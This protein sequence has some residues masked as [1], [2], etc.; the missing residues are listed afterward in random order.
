MRLVA[1]FLLSTTYIQAQNLVPNPGFELFYDCPTQIGQ[2]SLTKDWFS[3]NSGTPEYYN[4]QCRGSWNLAKGGQGYA[5]L[6]NFGHYNKVVEYI[7]AK[8]TDSLKKGQTYYVAMDVLADNSPYFTDRLDIHL[9]MNNPRIR[10]WEPLF[11]STSI[12][13]KK[14][15][16]D[17]MDEWVTIDGEF[18]ARGGERYIVI[19]NFSRAD[20]VNKIANP[21]FT[22]AIRPG[23][24]TYYFVDNVI[25]VPLEMK[26]QLLERDTSDATILRNE[27]SISLRP[28]YFGF[29]KHRLMKPELTY[30]DSISDIEGIRSYNVLLTGHTDSLGSDAYNLDLS[31]RRVETVSK[32]LLSRGFES[33][34]IQREF[35]GESRP[36]AT[37]NSKKG[38]AEN[39]RVSI[40]IHGKRK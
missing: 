21:N 5:G 2:F 32:Y 34:S 40:S 13:N 33:N 3:A 20:R 35:K 6:I 4:A 10:A 17:D 37:N 31:K 27:D 39:R 16:L 24:Y 29:D 36:I 12:A 1:L 28:V 8:L 23:W 9:S 26:S 7:A 15:I 18:E 38:R 19:G 30:L 11:R 14:G 25:V 22:G